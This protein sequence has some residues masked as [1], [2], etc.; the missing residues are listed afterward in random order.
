[1]KIIFD[2][3]SHESIY[4]ELTDEEY[5]KIIKIIEDTFLVDRCEKA[6]INTHTSEYLY[7]SIIIEKNSSNLE[8]DMNFI[9][10]IRDFAHGYLMGIREKKSST[11]LEN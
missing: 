7:D 2:I 3:L 5:N 11:N 9:N 4:G 8:D 10:S 1:M 6:R